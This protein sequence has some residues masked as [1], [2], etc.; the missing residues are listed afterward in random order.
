M[1]RL[2]TPKEPLKIESLIKNR[3]VIKMKPHYYLSLACCLSLTA[4]DSS[5]QQTTASK[6][7]SIAKYLLHR[8]YHL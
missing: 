8:I 7:L 4:Y 5:D 2:Y 3:A 1:Y 6:Q